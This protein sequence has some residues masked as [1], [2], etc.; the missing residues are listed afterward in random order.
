MR[1]RRTEERPQQAQP[2]ACA[3][4]LPILLLLRLS[5]WLGAEKGG[6]VFAASH[7]PFSTDLRRG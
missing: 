6:F 2:W 5:V 1:E 3:R 4:Y 7:V